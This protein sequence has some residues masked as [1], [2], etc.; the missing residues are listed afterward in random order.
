M[1]ITVQT[2]NSVPLYILKLK[3]IFEASQDSDVYSS[4]HFHGLQWSGTIE[5]YENAELH[6]PDK[7]FR[8]T[9]PEYN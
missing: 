2:E 4:V 6:S 1:V 7:L 5:M 3:K 9:V 8:S